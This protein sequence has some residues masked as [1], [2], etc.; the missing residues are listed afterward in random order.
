MDHYAVIGNPVEHSRSPFIHRQFALATGQSLSYTR[1][2]CP[3]DGFE[4]TARSF[5]DKGAHGCNVTVPFKFEARR[6][7]ANCSVRAALAGAVN[8]LRFDSDAWMGD[9]T[10][11]VG[12][13]RDI[14]VN[15]GVVIAGLRVLL[16]GAGGAAAGALG[17]L[18]NA[19]PSVL[20]LANR[21]LSRAQDL[22]RSHEH[23]ARDCGVTFAVAPLETCGERFDIIVNASSSSLHHAAVPVP[24]SVLRPGALALDMM[25]GPAAKSFLDW[26]RTH[27]AVPRD[28][29]GLLVEQAAESFLLWRGVRPDTLLVLAA[30]RRD[31]GPIDA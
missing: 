22:A 11:G 23:V 26:A 20:V 12:L 30:L 1:I 31:L 2:L 7:A 6:L 8:T 3:L 21:T 19:R 28:G 27:R 16:I 10:D 29:L 9:N 4:S 18:L 17:P 25:Y 14:E 24:A 15:A 13:V 5:A